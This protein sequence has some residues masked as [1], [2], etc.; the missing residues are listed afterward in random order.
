MRLGIRGKLFV[1]SITVISIT[2][3]VL[4]LYVSSELSATIEDRIAQDLTVRARLIAHDLEARQS[5]N[6]W[7]ALASEFSRK[8]LARVTLLRRDGTVLGDSEVVGSELAALENH[9]ARTEVREAIGAGVGRAKRP[10]TTIH[11]DLLYVAVSV[12]SPGAIGVVRLAQSLEPIASAVARARELFAWATIAAVFVA[13]AFSSAGSLLLSRSLRDLRATAELM[14]TN[15]KERTR[16]QGD[17]E[18]GAL[19]KTLDRLAESL[20]ASLE[21]L[22]RERDQLGAILDTI[23]EGVLVT[24]DTGRI[25]LANRALRAMLGTAGR[26]VGRAP[27][28]SIRSAELA[29]L[30]SSVSRMHAVQSAELEFSGIQARTLRVQAAPLSGQGQRGVVAVFSDLTELRRLESVRRDFVANVSHELRT[31]IAAVLAAAETLEDGALNDPSSA[32]SFVQIIGRHAKRLKDTVEDLLALSRIESQKLDLTL[33]PIVIQDLLE[34]IAELYAVAASRH[35]TGLSVD[36]CPPDA[37]VVADQRAVEQVLSNLVDNAVK[38]APNATVRVGTYQTDDQVCLYVRDTGP[39]IP[40]QHLSRVFERFYRV[41]KG[42]SREVGGTG[43]GLSI[44]KHL[45]ESMHGE[46]SVE[47]TVGKG[48]VFIVQLPKAPKPT[49][50][51]APSPDTSPSAPSPDTSPSA[52]SPD[53]SPSAPSPSAPSHTPAPDAAP[54][55]ATSRSATLAGSPDTPGT[56]PEMTSPR[57]LL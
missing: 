15:L 24:D 14:T 13:G 30:I 31:P 12:S 3:L 34:H 41:D 50:S 45:A 27:I 20:S 6:D 2:V 10:S 7:S 46:V 25:I 21:R 43:L 17:D 38:Y 16:L 4:N 35:H 39:G 48:T 42:R 55:D 11:R 52:P 29:E 23:V 28:E 53:T 51:T 19:G 47:S 33:E 1:M 57:A 9:A 18:V 49:A 56:S 40:P 44:V 32:A 37:T 36:P 26:L 5:E 54:S 22:E 8:A